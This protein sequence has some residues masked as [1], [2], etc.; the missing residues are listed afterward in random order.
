M[1]HTKC[2][3]INMS[4]FFST[5]IKASINRLQRTLFKNVEQEVQEKERENMDPSPVLRKKFVKSLFF[6]LGVLDSVLDL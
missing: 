6:P 5:F 4:A 1:F 3:L 2:E